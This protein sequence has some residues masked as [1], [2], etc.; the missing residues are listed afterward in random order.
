MVYLVYI[1][2]KTK[3]TISIHSTWSSIKPFLMN[4]NTLKYLKCKPNTRNLISSKCIF[5]KTGLIAYYGLPMKSLH[6]LLDL[7]IH[8][9]TAAPTNYGKFFFVPTYTAD[10][11]LLYLI[12]TL[13]KRY[14]QMNFLLFES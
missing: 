9:R 8:T 13:V 11:V 6:I 10:T 1:H 2:Y 4:T 7:Q 3:N 12:Y 14:A 5:L